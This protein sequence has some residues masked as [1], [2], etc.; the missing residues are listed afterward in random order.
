MKKSQWEF[1]NFHSALFEEDSGE[2]H[3]EVAPTELFVQRLNAG[4]MA[5]MSGTAE[6][7]FD[8]QFGDDQLGDT[9][10]GMDT[11]HAAMDSPYEDT[12]MPNSIPDNNQNPPEENGIA[13]REWRHVHWLCEYDGHLKRGVPVEHIIELKKFFNK[14]GW[15]DLYWTTV[16]DSGQKHAMAHGR[17]AQ[18]TYLMT[19]Q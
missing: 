10:K 4:S 6:N 14:M 12:P 11:P 1:R 8:R 15:K 9:V 7:D 3:T 13:R 18:Q 19:T 17:R 16:Y 2:T 5:S